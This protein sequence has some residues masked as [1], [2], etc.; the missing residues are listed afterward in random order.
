MSPFCPISISLSLSAADQIGLFV[1]PVPSPSF[2]HRRGQW[3]RRLLLEIGLLLGAP[4]LAPI[5]KLR[6]PLLCRLEE[7]CDSRVGCVGEEVK[8]WE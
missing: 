3:C 4:S 2:Q 5:S 1:S 7:I 8:W 6:L